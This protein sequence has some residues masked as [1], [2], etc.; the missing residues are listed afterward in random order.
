MMWIEEGNVKCARLPLSRHLWA[1]KTGAPSIY[2]GYRS[3]W[4]ISSIKHGIVSGLQYIVFKE[5]IL[6][7]FYAFVLM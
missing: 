3:E 1:G 6:H 2:V 5:Y 4:H 7:I